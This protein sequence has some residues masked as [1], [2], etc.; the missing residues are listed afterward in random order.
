MRQGLI[1]RA[2]E[3]IGMAFLCSQIIDHLCLR[4][5]MIY[6]VTLSLVKVD[7]I[8]VCVKIKNTLIVIAPPP[9]T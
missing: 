8:H 6:I 3:N 7:F 2:L 5:I 1:L 9:L 4:Q